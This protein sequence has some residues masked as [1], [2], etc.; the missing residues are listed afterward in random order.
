MRARHAIIA[1]IFA[2]A[3]IGLEG[4][5]SWRTPAPSRLRSEAE[6]ARIEVRRPRE[7]LILSRDA[8][9]P[10]VIARQDDIADAEAVEL[11]LKGLRELAFGPPI[12][13]AGAALA[14][15]LGPADSA[16]VRVLD[17]AGQ[18]LFDGL[19]GRR[20]FGQSSYFHAFD[21]D[22][23]RLATGVDPELL[24][25]SSAQWRE[26]RLLPGGCAAGIEIITGKNRRLVTNESAARGLCA[27]RASHWATGT[28]EGLA[29]F[30]RPLLRARTPEGRGFTVGERRGEERLV[31][32]DGR[33]ALLRIPAAAIEAMAA[34]LV[35]SAP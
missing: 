32:V 23:V 31:R 5:R 30:D 35:G 19:F 8:G 9:G 34:D 26:P 14:S 6:P 24:L 21:Q 28:P 12:A 4:L 3:L 29:G 20:L 22:V 7:D 33:S 10:W 11:L 16:R 17:S 2:F 18:P 27:L 15:G 13:K 1:T 25:R